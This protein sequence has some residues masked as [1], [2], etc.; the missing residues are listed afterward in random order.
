MMKPASTAADAAKPPRMRPS[1]QPHSGA[2]MMAAVRRPRPTVESTAPTG[3]SRDCSGSFE[4][5]TSFG[6]AISATAAIG[7]LMRNTAVQLNCSSSQPPLAGPMPTPMPATAAQMPIAFGR[8]SAGKTLVMI[9][10]VVGMI[11][12]PPTPMSALVAMSMLAD[13]AKA[14]ASDA[15]PKMARPATSAPRRLKR[16]P[17][18]PIVSRRPAKTRV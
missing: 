14:D 5:G 15:L 2:W 17:S 16:S 12:A 4:S 11:S 10:S 3:S 13:S 6:M 9:D 18:A 1:V 8:S 7:T